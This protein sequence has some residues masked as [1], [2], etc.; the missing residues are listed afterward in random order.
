MLCENMQIKLLG[1]FINL[2]LSVSV[3]FRGFVIVT[4]LIIKLQNSLAYLFETQAPEKR[5]LLT[6]NRFINLFKTKL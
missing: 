2:C 4:L 3:F 5:V 6:H 1:Y